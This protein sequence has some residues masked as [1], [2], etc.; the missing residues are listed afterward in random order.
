MES[1]LSAYEIGEGL[2]VLIIHGWEME[3]RVEQL[4]FEP[5][6][7]KTPGLRRIYVDLPGMGTTPANDV[8][9]LDDIYHHLVQFIDSRLGKT[10]FLLVGSSC[11]GYL[12][13]A[14]AQKYIAQVDG[15][16]LRVPLIEPNDSKRDLD[17]FKPLVTNEQLMSEISA[18]DRTLLG[19]VLV[20]TP[21]Y[22]KTLKAKY[23][24]VILP[25][26][27]AADNKV[28]DPIRADPDRYQLS[29][30]LDNETAKFFAPTLIVCGRQDGSVG[31]RDSLRLL[32]LYPRS[33]YV[34]LDRGTHG[35]PI[36]ETSVFEALVRDWIVRAH[37]WRSRT[38]R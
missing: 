4:D 32:E 2:P 34:V 31:Y 24:K 13:R 20:Q 9:D 33:T 10:R 1:T 3:G 38:D 11:G 25:A 35:L 8:K 19:D 36:D 28:L 27:E 18:E 21:A 23:E 16:L 15:L 26:M 12:A 30:L 7:N 17:A 29:F 14:I 6:F 22:I 5:I 37:E